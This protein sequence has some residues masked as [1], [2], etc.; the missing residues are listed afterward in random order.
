[1]TGL[2]VLQAG[3]RHQQAGRL[4]EAAEIYQNLLARQPHCADALHLLGVVEFQRG[5]YPAAK[6]WILRAIRLCPG[7]APFHHNLGK[8]E[9]A[10]GNLTEAV[11][12]FERA[13]GCQPDTAETL[14]SLGNA[15]QQA[16]QKAK[17]ISIYRQ[18]IQMNPASAE[19]HNN[20]GNALHD[21]DLQAALASYRQA[22]HL[23]PGLAVAHNNL[24]NA[25]HQAGFTE[26]GITHLQQAARLNPTYAEAHYNL[27]ILREARAELALAES[28]Y[29]DC[30]R[31]DPAHA[32]AHNNLG[33]LW[34]G[35][36]REED[37]LRSYE[38]AL[39]LKPSDAT[40]HSNILL[41]LHYGL[42]KSPEQ[43]F[44]AHTD[45]RRRYAESLA[46]AILSHENDSSPDRPLRIGYLS[47]D[48]RVH[49]VGFFVA[50]LLNAHDPTHFQVY[51]YSDVSRP[52]RIT[53]RIRGAATA[54]RQVCG[55]SDQQAAELIREDK[56]DILVDLAGHTSGSRL[57]VMA[58]KPAPVAVTYLGYPD[59]T[60]LDTVDYRFTDTWAD[61]AG[62]TEHLHSE[63]LVRLPGGFLC[64][65]APAGCP[66]ALEQPPALQT[67]RVTF[68]CFNNLAKVTAE[69]I[70]AWSV[71]LERAPNSRLVLKNGSFAE[72]H[73]RQM[74]G[75]HFARHGVAPGRVELAGPKRGI[76]EHLASYHAV[77][78]A[79]D[80]FPYHGT[81][82]TCEALWMG[83]PVLTLAGDTH[84][85][86]VGV[87]LLNQVGL[88]EL[89]AGSVDQYVDV[90]VLLASH[91][92]KL[93]GL[94]SFLRQ[95]M[96][97]SPLCD[98]NRLARQIERAYREMWRKWLNP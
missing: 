95:R 8:V 68:G 7:V 69:Q 85:S 72:P 80:T 2:D 19:T 84:A 82:T 52:D 57:L 3:V 29:M 60:G 62:L 86:R 17:A 67:G 14:L 36:G 40:I 6:K 47:A 56:I 75:Q 12:C 89:I 94:R 4:R 46:P 97:A 13:L 73:I 92:E 10:A 38:S 79:L 23:D 16:G 77:D 30:L 31:I 78:L 39:S 27:A 44:A 81:T 41:A 93:T 1:M 20:L 22:V 70:R 34:K 55:L 49:P 59:T 61:P 18:A 26:E 43:V 32:K 65:E 42:R 35:Q 90:A 21:Q 76:E 45:W 33:N 15:L 24:G 71:I 58:R 37:A 51:C 91:P 5:N 63:E 66:P 96:A 9:Q 83:V 50:P 54:W 88:G 11:T 25:L 74:V 53:G 28:S 98:A 64:Y 87:S 48:F